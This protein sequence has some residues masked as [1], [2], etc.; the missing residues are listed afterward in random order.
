MTKPAQML[1][2]K[3]SH[4]YKLS[5][6]TKL[7]TL[8]GCSTQF[9][10]NF[11]S[12]S[13]QYKIFTLP[14]P[15][16]KERRQVEDPKDFIKDI[17]RRLKNLL[18]VIEVPNYLKSGIKR[19]SHIDNAKTHISAN[20][21]VVM[22]L[23]GFYRSGRKTFLREMFKTTFKIVDD[24][25]W[26]LADIATIPQKRKDGIE[27]YFPTGSPFS[28]IIIFWCYKKTFDDID[29]IC[30]THGITFSLYVDDMTFSSP[31]KIPKSFNKLIEK[32]IES[33][34]LKLNVNKTSRYG[35]NDTKIITGC[36]IKDNNI[37]VKNK[38][39]QDII[40]ALQK[41][42]VDAMSIKDIRSTLGKITSQQQI[43]PDFMDCTKR[44]LLA[45]LRAL[46]PQHQ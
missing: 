5:S 14:K 28:Q 30:E 38:K 9:L 36:A 3:N 17:H 21:C 12:S 24:I 42:D 25:A 15:N 7:A 6:K 27:S 40:D 41:T 13:R 33:V 1:P 11:R 2:I 35:K 29:A 10:H 19:K 32:R 44:K 26:L 43:E 34:K 46:K 39:R 31:H 23:H 20:Y 45:K 4:L 8:L 18:S 22:D 16:S 37:F